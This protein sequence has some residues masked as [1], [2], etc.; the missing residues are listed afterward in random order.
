MRRQP[1]LGDGVVLK[2]DEFRLLR[3]LFAERIGLSFGPESRLAL[4]RRLRERLVVLKLS[5]FAEY[6]HHLRFG[7]RAAQEW[8]E[9]VDLLT[10]NE[11]YFFRED[12]QLRAFQNE[13]LPVLQISA[14]AQRRLAIWSAG[15][16]TGE[17]AYT[18]AILVHQSGLFFPRRRLGSP[19]SWPSPG[20][21]GLSAQPEDPIAWDV[22]I[23][24]S[25]ISKR[26]VATARRGVYAASSFRATPPEFRRAYFDESPDGWHVSETIRQLCQFGQTNLLD[27]RYHAFGRADVIFCR[28]VLI[29]F[30]ARA[31]K[32]AIAA[33]YERLN[34]G[35]ILL[36]GHSESLLNVSTAFELLH[37]R[38]DLV[39]RK[40]LSARPPNSLPD[41]ST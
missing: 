29:Y 8:D 23:F 19:P 26:C 21:V 22:R 4:E 33:L 16:S 38:E 2:P 7:A 15:C 35:G 10:T 20:A 6:H 36:L 30:D 27:D 5:S 37:L 3:D 12:R 31:R 17:E 1:P 39:Y 40:P 25:D 14:R 32:A 28:N 41:P 18:I 13:L 24:G 34:P 11:T 9:A